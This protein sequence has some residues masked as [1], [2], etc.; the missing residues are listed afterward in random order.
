MPDEKI[1]RTQTKPEWETV[2]LLNSIEKRLASI[3]S[4]LSAVRNIRYL[5][6]GILKELEAR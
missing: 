3:A 6:E 2:R 5:L 1:V 4:E